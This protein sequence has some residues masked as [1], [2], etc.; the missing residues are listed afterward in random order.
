M[1]V[2]TLVTLFPG[3]M[4]T[5]DSFT[6]PQHGFKLKAGKLHLSKIGD[7]K[8][9]LHRRIEGTIK[10]LTLR[11]T[12]TGK[13]FTYFSVETDVTPPRKKDLS[14]ALMYAWKALLPAPTER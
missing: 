6:Y 13:R 8:V 11:R 12:T 2:R 1:P 9:N 14:W 3:A 4:G 5:C 10:R 7:I